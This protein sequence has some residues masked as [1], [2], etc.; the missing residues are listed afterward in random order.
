MRC[1]WFT[2]TDGNRYFYPG[3]MGSAIYGEN[4]CTCYHPSALT[5]LSSKEAQARIVV[6]EK[7]VKRLNNRL[8]K[9]LNPTA[10]AKAG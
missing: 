3:C 5:T 8:F 6:L 7:E 1:H 9:L 2:H 10:N 4:S